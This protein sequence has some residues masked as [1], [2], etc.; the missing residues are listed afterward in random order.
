MLDMTTDLLIVLLTS[1]MTATGFLVVALARIYTVG[2][3]KRDISREV[4]FNLKMDA[5]AVQSKT[6][7]DLLM[8]NISMFTEQTLENKED[9]KKID[10]LI[11][12]HD[13]RITKL[14]PR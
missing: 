8:G 14:E 10:G 12:S 9:I 6:A 1:L 7:N 13:K 2:K 5:Q 3:K 11:H 4:N